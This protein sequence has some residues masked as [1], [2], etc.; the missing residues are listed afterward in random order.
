MVSPHEL[1]RL[2]SSQNLTG[3]GSSRLAKYHLVTT[4][5]LNMTYLCCASKPM[6][7]Y[8]FTTNNM[9]YCFPYHSPMVPIFDREIGRVVASGIL[10]HP[11]EKNS[12]YQFIE[13]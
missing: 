13:N 1:A 11:L 6:L 9:G 5:T 7:C 10:E 3:L 4:P 12:L 8:R 2:V